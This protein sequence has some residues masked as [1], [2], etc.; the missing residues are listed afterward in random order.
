MALNDEI[1]QI[2]RRN[3]TPPAGA[4]SE[5]QR[6]IARRRAAQAAGI[7]IFDPRAFQMVSCLCTSVPVENGRCVNCDGIRAR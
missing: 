2:I 6:E 5:W 4:A 3:H 7:P 1:R